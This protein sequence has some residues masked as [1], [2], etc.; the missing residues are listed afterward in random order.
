MIR[1]ALSGEFSLAPWRNSVIAML[2]WLAL[3]LLG[4]RPRQRAG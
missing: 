4:Y 3:A 1:F 2:L